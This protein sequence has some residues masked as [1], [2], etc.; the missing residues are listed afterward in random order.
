MAT[1]NIHSGTI[2]GKLNGVMPTQTPTGWRMVSLSTLVAMFSRRWPM[3]R[4]G[5]PQANSTIS[6]PR[7]TLARASASGFAMLAGDE[8]GQLV[9]MLDHQFAEAEHDPG[10]IDDRR[11]GPGGQRV[12]GGLARR[13]STSSAPHSGTLAM[14]LPR[15]GLKTSPQRL[16]LD[17]CHWPP[18]RSLTS[19]ICVAVFFASAVA[20]GQSEWFVV[21]SEWL[22]A[23]LQGLR[24]R[25]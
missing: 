18:M 15:D 13:R 10:A 14:T 12:G 22:A 16:A 24:T 17:D 19:A 21:S 2:A 4:L 8:R 11:F 1:G 25:V 23:S 3:I 20:M 6:M 7:C 9:E 5:M